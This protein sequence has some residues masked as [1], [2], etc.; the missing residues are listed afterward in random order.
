MCQHEPQ[1][2]HSVLVLPVQNLLSRAREVG[3]GHTHA[4]FPQ[5]KQS[6]LSYMSAIACDTRLTADGLDV[7]AR[8][9]ILGHHQF[10]QVNIIGER[11]PGG[12][13]LEDVPLGL[14]VRKR[15][16][17]NWSV[18]IKGSE[19]TNLSVYPPGPDQCR[20]ECFNLQCQ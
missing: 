19:P 14:R 12:V 16:F 11:H 1:Q 9:V 8:Q 10:L 2:A 4:P 20:I 13:E 6:S 15:E 17:C 7:G 3:F 18:I 5:S